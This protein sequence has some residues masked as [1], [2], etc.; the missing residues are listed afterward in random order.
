MIFDMNPDNLRITISVDIDDKGIALR[1]C[2]EIPADRLRDA[3]QP[4]KTND[5][6]ISVLL[7]NQLPLENT[8]IKTC[9]VE[10]AEAL[11]RDITSYLV[12][13]VFAKDDTHNGYSKND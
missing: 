4:I 12:N 7:D 2:S 13:V 6:A 1:A 11:A 8:V 3:L 9:R 10:L 5:D